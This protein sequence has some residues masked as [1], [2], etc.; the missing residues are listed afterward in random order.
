M[1]EPSAAYA[2]DYQVIC[3]AEVDLTAWLCALSGQSGWH[4]CG[5]EEGEMCDLY[6]FMLGER[7][8]QVALYRTGHATVEVDGRIVYDGQLTA[9][10]AYARLQYYNAESGEPILLN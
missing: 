7:Q 3:H 4:L 9:E 6:D 2:F 10:S 8:A 5:E 1:L